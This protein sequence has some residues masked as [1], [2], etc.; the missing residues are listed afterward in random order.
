MLSGKPE[1]DISVEVLK[2]LR[3]ISEKFIIAKASITKTHNKAIQN[4]TNSLKRITSKLE[5]FEIGESKSIFWQKI[6][7]KDK[8]W[9]FYHF[10]FSTDFQRPD[11]GFSWPERMGLEEMI[12]AISSRP[13]DKSKYLFELKETKGFVS[14]L[15]HILIE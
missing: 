11:G 13:L 8:V 2:I 9:I 15:Y 1:K 7:K 12:S 14:Y 4:I 3:K 5:E 6:R 10:I